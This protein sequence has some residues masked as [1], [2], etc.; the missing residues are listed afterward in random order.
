VVPTEV[1]QVAVA[2]ASGQKVVVAVTG[3]TTVDEVTT[4]LEGVT[5]PEGPEGLGL[6]PARTPN[7]VVYW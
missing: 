3:T 5:L 2:V 1:V 4:L 6:E 7:W